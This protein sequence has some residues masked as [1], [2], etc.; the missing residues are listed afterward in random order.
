MLLT[1][2]NGFITHMSILVMGC[3]FTGKS[4]LI[5]SFVSGRSQ[6]LSATS[7]APPGMTP[8]TP[9]PSPRNGGS[10]PFS[11]KASNPLSPGPSPTTGSARLGNSES[12][13]LGEYEPTIEDAVTI[14]YV[15]PHNP[16]YEAP[17]VE[18]PPP[19]PSLA[20]QGLV[21]QQQGSQGPASTMSTSTSP[22]HSRRPSNTSILSF[23]SS[24]ST[25]TPTSSSDGHHPPTP[26][27]RRNSSPT[28]DVD[29]MEVIPEKKRQDRQRIVVTIM[30]VGGHRCYSRV[31][32]SSAVVA[33]AVMLVYDVGER[34]SFDALWGFVKCVAEAKRV[35][36]KDIPFLLVGTMVDTVGRGRTRQ[37]A[38]ETAASFS[39]V[40]NIPF[41]ETTALATKSV[42]HCFRTLIE[43][44]QVKV[45]AI[46]DKTILS[47]N[48][49]PSLA[50]VVSNA[51]QGGEKTRDEV[52]VTERVTIMNGVVELG[53]SEA[54][55]A[56]MGSERARKVL[57]TSGEVR[58]AADFTHINRRP[59]NSFSIASSSGFTAT[60]SNVTGS[61]LSPFIGPRKGSM[62]ATTTLLQRSMSSRLRDDSPRPM[63]SSPADGPQNIHRFSFESRRPS[64]ASIIS[65]NSSSSS[66]PTT[67]S[68]SS[69]CS[70]ILSSSS[71]IHQQPLDRDP[72]RET[73]PG[74]PKLGSLRYKRDVA[75][76]AWMA[77]K[78]RGLQ[79]PFPR[80]TDGM[81]N[82]GGGGES[83]G[84]GKGHL[85]IEIPPRKGSVPGPRNG[86][87]G[88][89][90]PKK[91][92]GDREMAGDEIGK[93]GEDDGVKLGEAGRGDAV[94]DQDKAS[95]PSA[96]AS[97]ISPL[98]TP[99][100]E[101]CEADKP[102][103][104]D[105]TD[106]S[107]PPAVPLKS[108][109][110][111]GSAGVRSPIFE[112]IALQGLLGLGRSPVDD[113]VHELKGL[114]AVTF[115]GIQSG[116]PGRD[117][118]GESPEGDE[119]GRG[120]I[121][122]TTD[123]VST[124]IEL[125]VS[126]A[127]EDARIRAEAKRFKSPSTT[128]PPILTQPATTNPPITSPTADPTRSI[129]KRP[130]PPSI[131]YPQQQRLQQPYQTPNVAPV[132]IV[133][134]PTREELPPRN[135]RGRAPTPFAG[136]RRL[137]G[138]PVPVARPSPKSPASPSM[139]VSSVEGIGNKMAIVES[140][141]KKK[142]VEPPRKDP[143]VTMIRVP[144]RKGKEREEPLL[145]TETADEE[146][147]KEIARR[148]RRRK[149]ASLAEAR[150][151]LLDMMDELEAFRAGAIVV[152]E[153]RNG[154]DE[155]DEDEVGNILDEEP[156]Y[157]SM[158]WSRISAQGDLDSPEDPL[159]SISSPATPDRYPQPLA[160]NQPQDNDASEPSPPTSFPATSVQRPPGTPNPKQS[161]DKIHNTI[162]RSLDMSIVEME[163]NMVLAQLS[164]TSR[165]K[166]VETVRS[167]SPL[168]T[169]SRLPRPD[170]P[171]GRSQ[172]P[173]S[174]PV[175]GQ[176]RAAR[177][178]AHGD[179]DGENAVGGG[180]RGGDA[181][182]SASSAPSSLFGQTQLPRWSPTSSGGGS[183]SPQTR[184]R[185]LMDDA[186]G[187]NVSRSQS[188]LE[189]LTA[190]DARMDQLRGL[191]GNLSEAEFVDVIS[192][193]LGKD[194]RRRLP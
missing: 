66:S 169:G 117:V 124:R 192:G 26:M 185:G 188:P 104:T 23:F 132:E 69:L 141:M 167:V 102:R 86:G 19:P 175:P 125:E 115:S 73:Q 84:V 133:N 28:P 137:G 89:P 170:S 15:L 95:F 114:E 41:L 159:S 129:L 85:H 172:I 46:L 10:T 64:D 21:Q 3:A 194:Q 144:S 94:E 161:R 34:R 38:L 176:A 70:T 43:Q 113:D 36:P 90:V 39:K 65:Q 59:S 16:S 13:F 108:T 191:L 154:H 136:P 67:S 174:S 162:M 35:V 99:T 18:P 120:D 76:A 25:P 45:H 190:G 164:G 42:A 56:L 179:D 123:D 193:I 186:T 128:S 31:W 81:V 87:G 30:E 103:T 183:P 126:A 147:E 60:S 138:I 49:N 100:V 55:E 189:S 139:A 75:Y 47:I 165:S 92:L 58:H 153:G 52:E 140:T 134:T 182:S 1:D 130:T 93:I 83:L 118:V 98:T 184:R 145:T 150:K 151:S 50:A 187:T 96:H 109:A 22:E 148:R 135:T 51:H 82:L 101:N 14:Q 62:G 105:L 61:H 80:G 166:P 53:R 131:I 24:N 77:L 48:S 72:R 156:P 107:K 32:G 91:D 37:V 111:S 127:T 122:V 112:S 116:A 160:L 7:P 33:D 88:P 40:L 149:R 63:D 168:V 68:A 142:E 11:A 121:V 8:T 4:E 74:P 97:L 78:T 157:P 27:Y 110:E 173:R 57:M 29:D 152:D 44:T 106:P 2:E 54:L 163:M 180:R 6:T 143:P 71:T 171:A 181:G 17:Y 79:R 177:G 146:D 20:T 155:E 119:V 12:V 158:R 9:T 5:S 178:L